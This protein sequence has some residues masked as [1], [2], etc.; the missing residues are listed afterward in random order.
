[1][2]S[3]IVF[4][5]KKPGVSYAERRATYAVIMNDGRVATVESQQKHFLPGGGSLA[6]EASEDT[7]V[8][9]VGEELA[10]SVRLIRKLD[11]VVQYF[12][13]AADDRHYEMRAT[14]FIAEFTNELRDDGNRKGENELCWLSRAE[15]ERAFFHECHAW[16]IRQV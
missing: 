1:M 5:A 4:G 9:E 13:S 7:I 11:E 6:G 12:Y 8:R 16:A 2:S 15:A 3:E 10:R 14:F